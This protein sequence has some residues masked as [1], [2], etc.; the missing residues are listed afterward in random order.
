MACSQET[1]VAALVHRHCRHPYHSCVA[2][3]KDCSLDQEFWDI[4][5]E[6]DYRWRDRKAEELVDV[7]KAVVLVVVGSLGR[8]ID[9]LFLCIDVVMR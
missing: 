3:V 6:I 8:D 1:S 9:L 5:G 7:G 4:R 2:D